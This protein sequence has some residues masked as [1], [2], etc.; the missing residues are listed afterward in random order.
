MKYTKLISLLIVIALFSSCKEDSSTGPISDPN[1]LGVPI[2]DYMPTK[3][4]SKWVYRFNYN[5]NIGDDVLTVVGT[6]KFDSGTF[7]EFEEVVNDQAPTKSYR[8]FENGKY[9]GLTPDGTSSYI[10]DFEL[11]LLDQTANKGDKWEKISA[12]KDSKKRDSSLYKLELFDKLD[13]YKVNGV[14]YSDVLVMNTDIYIQT[15]A[16]SQIKLY[17]NVY[18][19]A[20]NVGIIKIMLSTEVE[21]V[22]HELV[23]YTP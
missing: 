12:I 15:E 2:G 22:V 17:E 18:Y 10:G 21:S 8:R 9:Y 1:D 4:G 5:G 7:V 16:G 20:R 11:L 13:T 19:Y 6:R 3:K 14:T 23:K